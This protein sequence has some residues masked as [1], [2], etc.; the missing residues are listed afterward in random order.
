MS[1]I[2]SLD[3]KTTTK[4]TASSQLIISSPHIYSRAT[5]SDGQLLATNDKSITNTNSSYPFSHLI[6]HSTPDFMKL[7]VTGN[8]V[9]NINTSTTY[10]ATNCFNDN[11][12][13]SQIQNNAHLFIQASIPKVL[14]SKLNT[15]L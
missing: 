6:F 8:G 4:S 10:C 7:D 9:L 2:S 3:L 13:V 15:W 5:D 14:F 11:I 1:Q 12:D